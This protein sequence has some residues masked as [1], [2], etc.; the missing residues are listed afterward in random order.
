MTPNFKGLASSFAQMR[1][2]IETQAK[3]A[4]A[5]APKVQADAIA[6]IK[7]AG[8]NLSDVKSFTS[9]LKQ[10]NDSVEGSNGGPPLAG[11]Q[12]ASETVQSPPAGSEPAQSWS[13]NK[14]QG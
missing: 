8:K 14:P 3:D 12:P 11:L 5:E 1:I 7:R 2:A 10:F 9:E 13:G 6:E 4:L